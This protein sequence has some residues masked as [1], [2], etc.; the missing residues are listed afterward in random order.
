MVASVIVVMLLLTRG[1][2]QEP[3]NAVSIDEISLMKPSSAVGTRQVRQVRQ[4]R[5]TV[6]E[7]APSVPEP[8][9]APRDVLPEHLDIGKY[10]DTSR[11][12]PFDARIEQFLELR[13]PVEPTQ[14]PVIQPPVIQPPVIQPPV[15]QP[16]VI[17]PR[18]LPTPEPV[19][20]RPET[21]RRPETMKR[22][23]PSRIIHKP[24]KMSTKTNPATIDKKWTSVLDL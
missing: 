17:Q 19:R 2:T 23:T 15:I 1:S 18:V 14:P 3:E 9:E 4:A 21:I 20:P 5:Q 8:R 16:P 6:R 10:E 24:L 11:K 7:P 13:Q 22:V 12:S